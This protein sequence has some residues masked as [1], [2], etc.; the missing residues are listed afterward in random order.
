MDKVRMLIVEDERIVA[1]DLQGRLNSM[2]YEVVGHAVSG[3][4]AIQKAE[5]LRPDMILMDI[6]LDGELDGI[7]AAEIIRSRFTIPVIYLTA[8]AD[9]ATLERAKITEPFGYILKPFEERELH[10]HIEI[11]LYKARM[12]KKLKDSEERYV[13]ATM[14]ANDGLWDWD[15][16]THK[17]YYS[18]RWKSM[19]GFADS[20]IGQHPSE[21]LSR[22]HPEDRPRV[23]QQISAH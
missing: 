18:P 5:A 13:L 12:E 16:T 19:L 11:A 4:E 14:G 2:G 1:M 9:S 3:E 7:Q 6:M 17:I 21:W 20:E 10:G 8:Y 15:L 22:L 23:K